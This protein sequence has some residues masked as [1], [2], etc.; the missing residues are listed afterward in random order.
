M[1]RSYVTISYRDKTNGLSFKC[2]VYHLAE[3]PGRLGYLDRSHKVCV[4]DHK[5]TV[6]QLTLRQPQCTQ[7]LSLRRTFSSSVPVSTRDWL[8]HYR[9]NARQFI[10][11]G[12]PT[13]ESVQFKST[14]LQQSP[15][16]TEI[17][18]G[19]RRIEVPYEVQ[20]VRSRSYS[21]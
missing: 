2:S 4:P 19:C 14:I 5:L 10:A 15:R 16:N 8:T 1:L 18:S 3:N 9:L 6:Y 11:R 20:Q 12:T 13:D 7:T 17:S 21:L